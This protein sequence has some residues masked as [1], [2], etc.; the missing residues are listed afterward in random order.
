MTT[1][2]P[3]W[4]G[5]SPEAPYG[6]HP[7]TGVPYS[8][9][10]KIVAGLLQILIPLGIGRMYAG[11]VGLGVGQLVVTIVTCGIGALW[12]FIDGIV[13]LVGDPTDAN[14]RPLRS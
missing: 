11:H 13:M 1:P 2:P 3:G 9:K 5:P 10:S 7:V 8:D 4:W 14:G 12:P 6:R